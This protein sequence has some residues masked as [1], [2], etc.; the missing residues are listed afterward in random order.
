MSNLS[1]LDKQT[2]AH[3][4]K[5]RHIVKNN[6]GMPRITNNR[7]VPVNKT[8]AKGTIFRT[9][10]HDTEIDGPML[11]NSHTKLP[12][13]SASPRDLPAANKQM[14]SGLSDPLFASKLDRM[15]NFSKVSLGKMMYSNNSLA[16]HE[17]K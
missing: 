9:V 12:E 15:E 13:K 5:T 8:E 6:F 2:L 16:K 10:L 1:T 11:K 17:R 4:I 14:L 7:F 3:S